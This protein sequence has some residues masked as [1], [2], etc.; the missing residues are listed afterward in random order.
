M[1]HTPEPWFVG[2]QQAIFKGK[3]CA[4]MADGETAVVADTNSNF[5]L[6][7]EHDARRIVAC[8]NACKNVDN[9]TLIAIANGTMSGSE[10]WEV[11]QLKKQIEDLVS[12]LKGVVR[13]ADR[14]TVEFDAA[15][16]AI[17]KAE[18]K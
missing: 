13:V 18:G 7:A 9:E 5:P 4:K 6:S 11:A 10:I 16:A 17:A 12:A 15:R 2:S 14:A 8:V 1:G 3:V